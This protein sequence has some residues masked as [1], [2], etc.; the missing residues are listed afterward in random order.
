MELRNTVA[1]GKYAQNILGTGPL[2]EF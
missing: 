1:F 2:S